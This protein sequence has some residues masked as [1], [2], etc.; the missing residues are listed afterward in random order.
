MK[1][2]KINSPEFGFQLIDT[3]KSL[4]VQPKFETISITDCKSISND[5]LVTIKKI[6]E[7]SWEEYEGGVK[8]E[9]IFLAKKILLKQ[10][11]INSFNRLN[12]ES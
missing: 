6:C 9:N 3:L 1:L 5:E 7:N 12:I 10:E 2:Y 4:I 8:N 11:N